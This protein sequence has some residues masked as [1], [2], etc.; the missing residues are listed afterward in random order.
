MLRLEQQPEQVIKLLR[1]RAIAIIGKEI[2]PLRLKIMTTITHMRVNMTMNMTQ[3][4]LV[5]KPLV[6]KPND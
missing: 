5:A 4:L 6:R 1:W 2:R 3:S